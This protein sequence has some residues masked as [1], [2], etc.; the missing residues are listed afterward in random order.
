MCC[1]TLDVFT[2]PS[3]DWPCRYSPWERGASVVATYSRERSVFGY[4]HQQAEHA[5]QGYNCQ[6]FSLSVQ[7]LLSTG[8]RT[9]T[10]GRGKGA[11]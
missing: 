11:P 2:L 10:P 6:L 5:V 3:E 9:V 4:L 7:R 1:T 8:A